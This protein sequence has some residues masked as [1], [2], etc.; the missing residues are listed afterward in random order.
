MFYYTYHSD[1]YVPQYVSPGAVSQHPAYQMFYWRFP[2]KI[3][4]KKQ[5]YYFKK[6]NKILSKLSYKSVT[7]PDMFF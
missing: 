2:V 5:Y 4:L 6:R 7:P 1:L 3:K